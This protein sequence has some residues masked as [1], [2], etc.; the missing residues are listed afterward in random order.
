MPPRRRID[1]AVGLLAY[2][3]VRAAL[4][5]MAATSQVLGDDVP[6]ALP[7]PGVAIPP[8]VSVAGV[9]RSELAT[10]VRFVLE[11]LASRAPGGSVELRVPPFGVAQLLEGPRHTRGTPPNVVETDPVTIVALVAG[12]LSWEESL[13]SGRLSASG[14]RSCLAPFFPVRGLE[15]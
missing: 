10:A 3:R 5:E 15:R 2:E 11:E 13:E 1:P 7:A 14:A 4:Q 9:P 6:P 12:L 8:A